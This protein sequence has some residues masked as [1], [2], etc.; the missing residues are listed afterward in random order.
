MKVK[1]NLSPQE[2][3]RVGLGL[4]KLSET[5]EEIVL[6]NPAEKELLHQLEF[7]FDLAVHNLQDELASLFGKD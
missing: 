1:T 5:N 6:E 2:L 4:V 3:K 7:A